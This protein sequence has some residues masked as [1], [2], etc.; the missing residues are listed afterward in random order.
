MRGLFHRIGLFFR[1]IQG[2]IYLVT[3]AIPTVW[4]IVESRVSGY[5]RIY[6][7]YFTMAVATVSLATAYYVVKYYVFFSDQFGKRKEARV[8]AGKLREML[9]VGHETLPIGEVAKIW[10][11]ECQ[12]IWNFNPKL[13][14]IKAAADMK[15][16]R[17]GMSEGVA[18]PSNSGTLVF[19]LDV[20][21]LL[22]SGELDKIKY[23][24]VTLGAEGELGSA[25]YLG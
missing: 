18:A 8:A 23:R 7:I 5:P 17:K 4:A 9:D 19:V 13:R 25:S 21:F 15:R 20:I 24:T 10:A 14:R 2:W 16:L 12:E 1:S 3:V 22:E 6:M 11:G